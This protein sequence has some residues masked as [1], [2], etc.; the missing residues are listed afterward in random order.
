MN[1]SLG[2]G[3]VSLSA[4]AL[5][6]VTARQ[7]QTQV[8]SLPA[9]VRLQSAT[10][11]T[12]QTGHANITGTAIAGQFIG[13]GGGLA[14]VNANLLDGLDSTSFLQG[15][16]NPLSLTSSP[17]GG[18]VVSGSNGSTGT[19]SSGV[20]G[21][22]T[23]ATGVT[24]GVF[25]TNSSTSGRGVFGESTA[26]TGLS[27]GGRFESDS[28]TGRGVYG[29]ANSTTGFAYGVLGQSQSSTG[30]GVYGL[31]ATTTGANYGGYFDSNSTEGV[32]LFAVCP[33]IAGQFSSSAASGAALLAGSSTAASNGVIARS[34]GTT[35]SP[36][37]RCFNGELTG[38]DA[39]NSCFRAITESRAA[40]AFVINAF[41]SAGGTSSFAG[42][43]VSVIDFDDQANGAGIGVRVSSGSAIALYGEAAGSGA[44]VAVWAF[45]NLNA[46][47]TKSFVIDHPL[48]PENMTLKHYCSEGPEPYNVYRGNVRLGSDGAAWVTLPR[49]FESINRDVSYQ[50]TCVGGFAQV[51]VSSEVSQNRFQI[52]GGKPGLKVSW[53]VTA[54]R[55]DAYV[56]H[57]GIDPEQMKPESER[58]LYLA[59]EAYGLP[60]SKSTSSARM[61][62][63][64]A[65]GQ[66]MVGGK[67][68]SP[69]NTTS[70][71][72]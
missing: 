18:P 27:Y 29:L 22:S 60:R 61:I 30:R 25:G 53:Q 16:P 17:L 41:G 10:P 40:N 5:L 20:R 71:R 11:G 39:F 46:T 47:G 57:Y 55:N 58:G 1:R 65:D 14:N 13:G 7:A 15:V 26:A 67:I 66:R 36:A 49:Y 63:E 68:I 42:S 4:L 56:R 33:N 44:N 69:A 43:A 34:A 23:A 21:A 72:P 50:L 8:G 38:G 59:P 37:V 32:G 24:Y 31:A 54:V 45:G 64:T 3:A 19:G 28:T 12:A 35:T 70:R 9:Y 48:D 2:I 6:V 51:Y 52:A 62:E